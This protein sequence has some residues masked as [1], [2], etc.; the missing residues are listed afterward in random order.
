[1]LYPFCLCQKG[2]EIFYIYEFALLWIKWT[3]LSFES[4][5]VISAY[6]KVSIWKRKGEKEIEKERGEWDFQENSKGVWNVYKW[7]GEYLFF[8]YIDRKT[9]PHIDNS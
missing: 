9:S 1:M 3:I 6:Y 2:G 7:K 4:N 8:T 5:C